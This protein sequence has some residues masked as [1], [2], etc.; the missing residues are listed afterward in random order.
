MMSKLVTFAPFRVESA[1]ILHTISV[2]E[3]SHG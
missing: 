2:S 3:L 1:A